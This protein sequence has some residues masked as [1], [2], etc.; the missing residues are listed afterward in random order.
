LSPAF[1]NPGETVDHLRSALD[2]LFRHLAV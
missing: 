2:V 1:D